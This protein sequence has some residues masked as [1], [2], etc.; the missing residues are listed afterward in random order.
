MYKKY[1]NHVNII[2]LK[3]LRKMDTAQVII[4]NPHVTMQHYEGCERQRST[5]LKMR[6]GHNFRLLIP[7]QCHKTSTLY[8]INAIYDTVIQHNEVE[9]FP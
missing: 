1:T 3:N 2:N 5:H 7:Q 6:N 4:I 9:D 8:T